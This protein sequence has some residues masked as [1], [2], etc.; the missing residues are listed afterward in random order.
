MKRIVLDTGMLLGI[1]RGA[2]WAGK[3]ISEFNLDKGGIVLATSVVCLGEILSISEK[4]R[5]GLKRKE[6]LEQIIEGITILTLNDRSVLNAYARINTWTHGGNVQITAPNGA[7]PPKPAISMKQNDMWV[8]ATTHSFKGL[9]LSTDKDF[10][11]LN[12]IWIDYFYVEQ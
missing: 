8:A 2:P 3:V 5:W 11:H 1:V 10:I 9:L 7:P 6:Y 4:H 12:N